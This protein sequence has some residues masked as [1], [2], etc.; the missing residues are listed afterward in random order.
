MKVLV[1]SLIW[2]VMFSS[3]DISA[4]ENEAAPA[5][6]AV[7]QKT[8]QSVAPTSE[9][10]QSK[11]KSPEE[12]QKLMPINASDFLKEGVGCGLPSFDSSAK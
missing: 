6:K 8:N 12:D 11:A 4:V 2:V 7:D 3:A 1:L 5:G 10:Q 9:P